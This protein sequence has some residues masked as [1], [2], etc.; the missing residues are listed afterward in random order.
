[1]NYTFHHHCNILIK[2]NQEYCIHPRVV[3]RRI[4]KIAIIGAGAMGCLYG[5]KLSINHQVVLIDSYEP[6]IQAINENGLTL[7]STEGTSVFPVK[8]YFSGQYHAS[9]DLVIVFVKSIHTYDAVKANTALIGPETLVMTLQN[10]AGNDR[11]IAQF[12]N[13]ENIIVGTSKHNCVSEGPGIIRHTGCGLTTIGYSDGSAFRNPELLQA[14][15]DAGFDTEASE[16]IQR[17]IWS[18]LFVNIS[19]NTL[20][21][22]LD[23]KI[24]YMIENDYAWDFAKRIIYEA[25]SVAEED[26]TYFD[27]RE[28]LQNV[29]SVC[30]NAGEGYSSMYQDKQRKVPTE[31]DKL[32]G[33]IVEQAKLYGVATPYNSLVVDLIHAVEGTYLNQ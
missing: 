1:M 27:R 22:L 17:I 6:Q 5:A 2:K 29:R 15:L 25:I 31:I 18:K 13:K 14:F 9:V 30:E 33:A 3:D 20:T 32:N 12:A 10:G 8:A 19:I 16:D 24:G 28:V 11:D 21:A 23:T 4:M 26:G 7:I